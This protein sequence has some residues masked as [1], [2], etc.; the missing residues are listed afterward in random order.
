M[1]QC[2]EIFRDKFSS[3]IIL[4]RRTRSTCATY[5]ANELYISVQTQ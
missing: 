4:K 3:Y 2:Y 1:D 5:D